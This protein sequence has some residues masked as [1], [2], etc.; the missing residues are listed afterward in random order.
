MGAAK[1]PLAVRAWTMASRWAGG[2]SG[3]WIP[4]GERWGPGWSR[5][6]RGAWTAAPP[7]AAG[8]ASTLRR[9]RSSGKVRS[10]N[11]WCKQASWMARSPFLCRS[12]RFDEKK[13]VGGLVGPS[14]YVHVATW[15]T[16]FG[17]GGGGSCSDGGPEDEGSCSGAPGRCC[18]AHVKGA[19]GCCCEVHM[20]GAPGSC[21]EANMK[22]APGGCCEVHMKGAPGRCCEAHRKGAP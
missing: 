4:A 21:C 18:K 10:W 1:A 20:K 8:A 14:W 16:F 13:L 7:V 19:P 6:T 12:L 9:P 3:V 5:S 11:S 2:N 22:G 15:R 17:G